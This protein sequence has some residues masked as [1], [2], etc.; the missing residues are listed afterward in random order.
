MIENPL[1]LSA[2]PI[3]HIIEF[4]MEQYMAG[5]PLGAEMERIL[6]QGRIIPQL[7]MQG[8]VGNKLS[9]QP[10]LDAAEEA[11]KFVK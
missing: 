5:K 3:G 6:K 8:A 4:Q 11:M 7:W 1:Y 10:T 9:I 2:Y